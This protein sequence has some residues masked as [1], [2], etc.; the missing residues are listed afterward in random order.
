MNP[1][2]RFRMNLTDIPDEQLMAELHRREE[3]ERRFAWSVSLMRDFA[4]WE[5]EGGRARKITE[6]HARTLAERLCSVL[7]IPR[8]E[9]ARRIVAASD[10]RRASPP[11]VRSGPG[12]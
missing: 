7:G 4:V 10:G 5:S 8:E 1:S 2:E 6:W 9:F 12:G 3:I 11:E